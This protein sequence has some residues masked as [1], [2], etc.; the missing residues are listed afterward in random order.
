MKILGITI[1]IT[2]KNLSKEEEEFI[3]MKKA[4][5]I[6]KI[7]N[8]LLDTKIENMELIMEHIKVTGVYENTISKAQEKAKGKS[9]KTKK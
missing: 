3:N 5:K 1:T 6:F 9:D 7:Q 2:K 8:A 4:L